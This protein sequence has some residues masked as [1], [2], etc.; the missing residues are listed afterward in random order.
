MKVEELIEIENF[1]KFL[2][3][4]IEK[5]MPQL[6]KEYENLPT[7]ATSN[8]RDK[9]WDSSWTCPKC[10]ERNKDFAERDSIIRK[11]GFCKEIV[12]IS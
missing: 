11:C 10:K 9:P 2:S 7:S 3:Y 4:K 12:H 5:M 8:N 6:A 1:Q